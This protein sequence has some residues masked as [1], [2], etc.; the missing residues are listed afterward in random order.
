M[1]ANSPKRKIFD[2]VDMLTEES[3][4]QTAEKAEG[5]VTAG[6]IFR[7]VV[8]VAHHYLE[9]TLEETGTHCDEEQCGNHKR[10]AQSVG[11]CRDGKGDIAQEH[12]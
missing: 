10:Y 4:A 6:G 8:K 12:H 11:G 1:K 5:G 2:A 9:I 3:S 7:V